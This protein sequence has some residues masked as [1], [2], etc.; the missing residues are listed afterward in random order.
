MFADDVDAQ[1]RSD[2]MQKSLQGLGPVAGTEYHYLGGPILVRLTGELPPS[3]A[4]EY[5]AAVA[6]P[7]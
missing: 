7:P 5:E 3:V 1:L 2:Y 4:A 6:S